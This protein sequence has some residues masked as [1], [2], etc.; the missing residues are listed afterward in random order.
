M[1]GTQPDWKSSVLSTIKPSYDKTDGQSVSA[2]V[3]DLLAS[4]LV[5]DLLLKHFT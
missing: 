3:K 2:I 4:D 1:T 5:F